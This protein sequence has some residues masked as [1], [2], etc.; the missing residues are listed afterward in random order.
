MGVENATD[1]C[2]PCCGKVHIGYSTIFRTS[3]PEDEALF[4]EAIDRGGNRTAGEHDVASNG[5]HR[6]R[7][8]MQK[9]F[10]DGKV[11]DA[12]PGRADTAGV[13]LSQSSASLHENE[14]EMDAGS[15]DWAGIRIAH[16]VS[17]YQDIFGA[18]EKRFS[19][20]GTLARK[21][22]AKAEATRSLRPRK[23]LNRRCASV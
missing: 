4:L 18:R 19:L 15:V 23:L 22:H 8:L 6:E 7:S 2:S 13:E 21:N 3:L 10:Q 20:D 12:E 16:G 14:P 1:E 9:N 5:I 11:R 17:L